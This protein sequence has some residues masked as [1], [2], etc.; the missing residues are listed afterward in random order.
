MLNIQMPDR[1]HK[2]TARRKRRALGY[3]VAGILILA[4]LL[5]AWNTSVWYAAIIVEAWWAWA[6]WT[7]PEIRP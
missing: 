6:C 7:D 4:S 2:N 5:I 3:L 1:Y